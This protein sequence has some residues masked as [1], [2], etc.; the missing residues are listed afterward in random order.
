MCAWVMY[1]LILW[2]KLQ[3]F[4]HIIFLQLVAYGADMNLLR[5]NIDNI[6]RNTET[7][8]DPSKEF[9]LKINVEKTKYMFYIVTR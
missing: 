8:I 2:L 5:N 6:K 7:L 1:R 4:L 9:R 3:L